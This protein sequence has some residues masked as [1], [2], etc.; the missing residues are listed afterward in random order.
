MSELK[1][2]DHVDIERYMGT[3][4]EI[5]KFPQRFEDG[6]VGI[7]ATYSLLSNGKVRVLNSGYVGDFNGKLKTAKGKAWVVDRKTNAKLKV[8]FF[9]PFAGDYWI[10]ELGKDYEYAVIGEVSRN[11]MW[12][13][14]RTPK[15]KEE[16]YEGIVQR[17]KQ[18]EFDVSRIELNP[19]QGQQNG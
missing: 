11:Y 13:L 8:S 2:V 3:W 17:L 7:T 9:W 5:A 4:Y 18:K 14:S 10:I 6:L 1:T 19:Q 15:M 12:I 16:V